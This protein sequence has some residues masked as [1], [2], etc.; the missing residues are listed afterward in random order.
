MENPVMPAVSCKKCNR[1]FM[2][3]ES[4]IGKTTKCPNCSAP[5]QIGSSES[6]STQAIFAKIRSSPV[7]PETSAQS[8]PQPQSS[9][10]STEKPKAHVTPSAA[11]PIALTSFWLLLEAVGIATGRSSLPIAVIANYASR[12][13]VGCLTYLFSYVVM[14]VA[15]IGNVIFVHKCWAALPLETH[16]KSAGATTGLLFVPIFNYLWAFP[17]VAGLARETNL[18]LKTKGLTSRVSEQMAVLACCAFA[19]YGVVSLFSLHASFSAIALSLAAVA[20]LI[21]MAGQADAVA[22]LIGDKTAQ[23]RP[24][25]LWLPAI[26]CSAGLLAL[27]S[28]VPIVGK[29]TSQNGAQNRN[30]VPEGTQPNTA[31]SSFPNRGVETCYA[32][33]GTGVS[34]MRSGETCRICKGRGTLTGNA[35]KIYNPK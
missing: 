6:Q 33:Q 9:A 4:A 17:A 7:A 26:Y 2:A 27:I 13:D 25:K 18:E 34:Q 32:C 24:Q 11:L 15:L 16:K 35:A 31:N 28:L 12:G 1:K 21:W 8:V 30:S 14:L 19:V 23:E 22:I 29:G 5:I 3:P 20:F 10:P